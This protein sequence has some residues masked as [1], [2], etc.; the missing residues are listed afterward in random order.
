MFLGLTHKHSGLRQEAHRA[1]G[2]ADPRE[3]RNRRLSELRQPR[4]SRVEP[5]QRGYGRAGRYFSTTAEARATS[6]SSSLSGRLS[7]VSQRPRNWK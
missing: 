1:L 7:F 2:A 3:R 6:S 5:P 4:A